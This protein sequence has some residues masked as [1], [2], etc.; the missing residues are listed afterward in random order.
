MFISFMLLLMIDWLIVFI[1]INATPK[2]VQWEP[3]VG[4]TTMLSLVT[5]R[6]VFVTACGAISRCG[7][8]TLTAP[9]CSSVHT[10][11]ILIVLISINATANV[12]T[13][14]GAVGVRTMSSLM[15]PHVVFVTAC[16]ATGRCGV[17][18]LT[19]PLCSSIYTLRNMH[20]IRSWPGPT[21]SCHLCS[22]LLWLMID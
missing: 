12:Y 3:A 1:S 22:V 19:A 20:A 21:C 18:S 6:V 15:A 2:Y 9:L 5:P 10:L 7:V 14:D 16:G 11:R 4:V 8:V 13:G 17:V